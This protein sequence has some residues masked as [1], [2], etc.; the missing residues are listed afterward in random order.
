M[1]KTLLL[2]AVFASL[3]AAPSV[4]AC[5]P[6]PGYP[7]TI[8]ANLAQKDAAFIGTVTS[9][10]QDKS[11]N[12]DYHITFAVDETY[13]GSL[14]DTVTIVTRSSSAACGYDDGYDA[15][16]KGTVWAI[17]ADGS[18]ADGYTT[19]SLSLNTSY[20]SVEAATEALAK[21]GLEPADD[22]PTMCTMIYAPVC[23]KS[24][25]GIVK[26][27]GSSCTLGAE[28]A[29]F[30]YEGECAIEVSSVPTQDLWS[31]LRNADVTWLQEFLISKVTGAASTALKS[32][33]AT[34]Y[35]GTLTKNALAEFQNMHSV[36]PAAGYFGAKTRAAIKAMTTP[37]V[38][39]GTTSF[40]GEISAVN[41]GCFSDGVC[42]VTVDGKEV[43]L[44]T[45]MRINVPPVGTLQGVDSIGDLESKIGTKAE[46][47]A[48]KTSEGD[49]GYTLYGNASYYVKVLD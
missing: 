18:T 32:V 6:A 8:P 20:A 36:S 23:G 14:E 4:Y 45:G 48:A 38:P 37:V 26:T 41:T 46:V 21:F 1:K 31:G 9:V 10:V 43:I 12:G 49:A 17:Y 34:G 25:D 5:S 27:Y 40:T 19:N 39:E 24:A 2:L 47:Y 33:G 7:P 22:A 11:V 3:V 16:E 28:K 42:S 15:F 29:E 44:L 30:L 13:K 35:F